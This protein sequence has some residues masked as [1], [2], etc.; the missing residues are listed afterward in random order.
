MRSITLT[1]IVSLVV[2]QPLIIGGL[3]LLFRAM[4]L[5]YNGNIE[6][7]VPMTAIAQ[8]IGI[9]FATYLA[10]ALHIRRIKR[11]PLALALKVQE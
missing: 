3:T 6:I 10:V 4:L 2:C 11:V 8:V 9:G 1:V 5:A 7:Y